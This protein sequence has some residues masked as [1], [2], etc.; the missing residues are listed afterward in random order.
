MGT[1]RDNYDR[2]MAESFFASLEAEL[3]ERHR[4]ESKA[5]ACIAFFT[6]IEGRYN[7]RRRHSGLG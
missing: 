5:Q 3:I 6:W 4:F 2:A 7:P 1:V